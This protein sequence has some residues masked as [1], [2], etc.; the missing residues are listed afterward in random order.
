MSYSIYLPNYTI[1][2]DAYDGIGAICSPYGTTVAVIG[3]HTAMEAARD[4][5]LAALKN[6]PLTITDWFWYGGEASYE[7]V[8]ALKAEEKIAGADMIFGVGGGKATDTAKA[9]AD[10]LSKPV[11]TFPT[12][13][14]NCSAC[15]AVSI[16]YHQDKTFFK[17]YFFDAPPTHAFIHTGIIAKSPVRYCWAGIGDTYA[18]YFESTMSSRNE[19]VPHY[20][21]LGVTTSSMCYEP[22]MRYGAKALKDMEA[23]RSSAELTQVILSVVVTTGIAS[24][25]LTKDKIIDYNTGLGHAIFYALTSFPVI[26]EKHLHGEVVSYGIL[27]LLL[28]DGNEKD[29]E[30]VYAYSREVGLPTC[31]SDMELDPADLGRIADMA[32]RMKDIDHNPYPIDRDMIERAMRRLEEMQR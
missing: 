7:N 32:S 10:Q 9:V 13:A 24:I 18:K 16:M 6:T 15:T 26:E 25:L 17:P 28:V 12:I 23:G 27:V 1:G 14:S 22:M 20:V 31:L 4:Y 5:L 8:E 2:D 19:E 29:F 3:G 21:A 30:R 11:F